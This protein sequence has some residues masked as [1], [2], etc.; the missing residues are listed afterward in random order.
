VKPITKCAV[1]VE[2]PADIRY[3]LDQAIHLA[4][5]GRQ[6]PV[7]LDIPLD[8]QAAEIPEHDRLRPFVPAAR[9]ARDLSAEAGQ[10]LALL[11]KAERP[12]LLLGNGVRAAGAIA[13]AIQFAEAAQIPVLTT[14][15]AADFLPEDHPLFAGRPGASGQRGANFT[16]QNS[17]WL[18]S[19][20]ARLDFGQ[21]AYM[22]ELFARGARKL[23]VDVDPAELRKLK[24]DLDL[25]LDAD[26]GEFFRAALAALSRHPQPDRTGWLRRAADWK[27]RYPVLKPEYW[28]E[29]GHVN[30]YVLIE[31]LS[32]MLGDG[33]VLAPGSSGQSSELTC[34]A[35]RVRRG[36]RML[37]SQGLGPMGFGVPAALGA[38][39]A[40][41]GKR[42]VC[43]DGDGGFHMN[44]Q[45]LEVI[46]RLNLPIT[47][48]VLD[49]QGYG[50][51]RSSQRSHFSGR[52]V[53]SDASSGLTLPDTLAVARGYGLDTAVLDSHE[54]IRERMA[55]LLHR[56]GP[57]V[58]VVKLDPDQPTLPRV[59]SYMKP[60]GQ[61]ATRP[62]EDM[63]PYLERETLQ[64]EMQVPL[65]D[66]PR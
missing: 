39:I 63:F 44:L 15:K 28:Q 9:P 36:L 14:W 56:S 24:M 18:L 51:I 33:D 8:V 3:H 6:G 34:Q 65:L 2:D 26:A 35:L 42:T 4:R 13:P 21:I 53:A 52:L 61:M 43:V 41:G 45:E 5:T 59:T 29:R 20:G 60:D 50:S 11:Q 38:C 62:M 46:R 10:A 48:F 47:F 31:V 19:V 37:N 55:E 7:W 58:C 32:D 64:A 17:D 22:H 54:G 16:Q 57:Q 1:T 12:V 23:V 25:A 49:N 66:I 40:S 30:A 27:A